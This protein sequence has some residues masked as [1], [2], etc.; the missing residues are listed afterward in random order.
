MSAAPEAQ[1]ARG[2]FMRQFASKWLCWL[3][4]LT[5]TLSF[6]A[7]GGSSV[8]KANVVASITMPFSSLSLNFGDTYLLRPTALD[9]NGA[10]VLAQFTYTSDNPNVVDVA[11]N[12]Y[13]CAGKWDS[14]TTPIVCTPNNTTGTANIT[15]TSQTV[16][17]KVTIYSHEKVDSVQI[18]PP[19]GCV[20]SQDTLQLTGNAYSL[21]PAVC[22]RLG[23][24]APPCTVP[25]VG[26][27][28]WAS[29][30]PSI[31][32]I[33]NS[34]NIGQAK[35]LLP[36]QTTVFASVSQN[37]SPAV[38]FTTC[39]VAQISIALD[40][41]GTGPFTLAPKATQ[42]ITATAI[43]SK[44]K[45][46]PATISTTSGTTTTT[47]VFTSVR[48]INSQPFAMNVGDTTATTSTKTTATATAS[49][50][51]TTSIQAV[52]APPNCNLG[53]DPVYSNII[54]G[55]TSGSS[56]DTL[57][58]ASKDSTSLVPV[59]LANSNKV[60]TAITLSNTPTSMLM[61]RN[62]S[63][64]LLGS[65]TSAMSVNT[66]TSAVTSI[67][68]AAE[69]LAF[70]PNS[71]YF[72]LYVPSFNGVVF[73]S[74]TQL[75][76]QALIPVTGTAP[77][78]A[79]TPDSNYGFVIEGTTTGFHQWNPA[80]GELDTTLATPATDIATFAGGQAAYLN[81]GQANSVT[82][83]ATCN[84]TAQVD[85]QAVNAP[86]RVRAIPDGSGI[87]VFD[88]PN[89][90]VLSGINPTST[91]PPAI[92]ST[93]NTYNAGITIADP[94]NVWVIP[95][96]DSSKVVIGTGG[97]SVYV[98]N[99]STH[100][101]TPIPLSGTISA[102]YQLDVTLDSK[103]AYVGASDGKVHKLDLTSNSDVGQIDPGLQKSD[104]TPA[105]PHF[106]GLNHKP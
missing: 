58:V 10:T 50:P 16:S 53:L 29:N 66:G 18:T 49:N 92:S 14:D 65:A 8:P 85:A 7:C 19:S 3:A 86:Q 22:T 5:F 21:D 87:V 11:T 98:F 97:S 6:A 81:G 68:I 57:F 15:I 93:E 39:P 60:G 12:G 30:N 72:S 43:D 82:A 28:F 76:A 46:L 48:W 84:I 31:V 106:V 104:K 83:R 78:V 32:T 1:P 41:G 89:V 75:T 25:N 79:F 17:T 99:L 101:T 47:T 80:I 4:L 35:A 36:G 103:F 100:T 61:N 63:S 59:D 23:E 27:F 67:G 44:G 70:S 33:D 26:N 90:I 102:T 34:T 64:L 42:K 74:G 51:G 2:G 55:T 94:A 9:K 71:G 45:T 20:S 77:G 96:A 54:V 88:A 52:C 24:G 91:C 37:N 62:G 40:G 69:P 95:T 13:I 56:N 105:M 73:Y 38:K